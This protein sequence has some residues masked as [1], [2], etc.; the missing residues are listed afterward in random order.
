[1]E[2]KIQKDNELLLIKDPLEKE[3]VRMILKEGTIAS[4]FN[5]V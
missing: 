2:D 3:M 1:M 5:N 4:N